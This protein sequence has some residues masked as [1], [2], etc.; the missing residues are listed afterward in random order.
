MTDPFFEF[1]PGW[2]RREVA[3]AQRLMTLWDLVSVLEAPDDAFFK[4]LDALKAAE[5][6]MSIVEPRSNK[7]QYLDVLEQVREAIRGYPHP[8]TKEP[9]E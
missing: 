9:T 6:A 3:S 2:L 1:E 4:C 5:A 8:P 7:A